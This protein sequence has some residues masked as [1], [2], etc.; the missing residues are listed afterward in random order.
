MDFTDVLLVV[1]AGIVLDDAVETVT[2][3]VVEMDD[4]EASAA[5]EHTVFAVGTCCQEHMGLAYPG[6]V[7]L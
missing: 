3:A 6:L 5:S 1:D 7:K 4:E 2:L